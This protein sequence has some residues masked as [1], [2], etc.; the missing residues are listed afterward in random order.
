MDVG[1]LLADSQRT[2][3]QTGR[4]MQEE[5]PRSWIDR[6]ERAVTVIAPSKQDRLSC[7]VHYELGEY[8]IVGMSELFIR[9]PFRGGVTA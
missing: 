7:R 1:H 8:L 9:G 6:I 5:D 2:S 4:D 3:P